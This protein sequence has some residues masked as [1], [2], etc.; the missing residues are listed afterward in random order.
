ML[1]I[2]RR[3]MMFQEESANSDYCLHASCMLDI[4]QFNKIQQI[5][6]SK[7]RGIRTKGAGTFPAQNIKGAVVKV[8]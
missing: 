1:S 4:E 3:R 7:L 5:N 6:G 2:Q 8:T